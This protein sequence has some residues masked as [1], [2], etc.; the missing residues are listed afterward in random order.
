MGA[1]ESHSVCTPSSA[2]KRKRKLGGDSDD[3]DDDDDDSDDPADDDDD[4]EE[5]EIKKV[6]RVETYD[7]VTQ[8]VQLLIGCGNARG[9][10]REVSHGAGCVLAGRRGSG[11]QRGGAGE[12]DREISKGA[13]PLCHETRLNTH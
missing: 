1:E 7:E 4:E 3:D 6:K 13:F 10:C 9:R 2:A 5:E 8:D 11:H 12:A